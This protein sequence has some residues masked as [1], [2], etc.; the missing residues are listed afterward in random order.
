M[1]TGYSEIFSSLSPLDWCSYLQ[2]DPRGLLGAPVVAALCGIKSR[3]DGEPVT[4]AWGSASLDLGGGGLRALLGGPP[5]LSVRPPAT[6]QPRGSGGPWI[7]NTLLHRRVLPARAASAFPGCLE[8]PDTAKVGLLRLE[9]LEAAR[10]PEACGKREWRRGGP[11]RLGPAVV[12]GHGLNCS[13]ALDARGSRVVICSGDE[14]YLVASESGALLVEG[15]LALRTGCADYMLSTIHPGGPITIYVWGHSEVE[16]VAFTITCSEGRLFAASPWGL[17]LRLAPGS[18]RLEALG[19]P[20]A[21]GPG[22]P[23]EAV[24]GLFEAWMPAD[25]RLAEDEVGHARCANCAGSAAYDPARRELWLYAW[26]PT[27]KA[28]ILEVRLRK[29]SEARALVIDAHGE[30]WVPVERGLFRVPLPPGWH[31]LVN[32]KLREGEGLADLLR[33]RLG[34]RGGTG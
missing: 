9:P 23:L 3:P 17:K 11:P 19:G 4:L 5:R 8:A 28:G 21:L 31:T 2:E 7:A 29:P 25:Y 1:S 13:W 12:T 22:G 16:G 18:M 24:R 20:V 26:T 30:S 6:P 32:V 10:A 33:S 27:G 15:S 34:R 14:H